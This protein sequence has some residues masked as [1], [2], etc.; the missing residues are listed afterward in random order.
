MDYSKENI[1]RREILKFSVQS[2]ALTALGPFVSGASITK[3]TKPNTAGIIS[4]PSLKGK[5]VVIG[6][7]GFW[8][9]DSPA[10][11]A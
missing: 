1:S 7:G 4:N 8:R 6:A 9:M 11:F 3:D 2:A 10:P 5:I